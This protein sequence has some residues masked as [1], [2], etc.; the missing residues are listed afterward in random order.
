M[1]RLLLAAALAAAA[2]MPAF[3]PALAQTA[4]P[5]LRCAVDVDDRRVFQGRAWQVMV[6]CSG[7][8]GAGSVV[9]EAQPDD[10][11][12]DLVVI[13]AG[14]RLRL[15]QYAHGL[16]EGRITDQPGVISTRGTRVSLSLP[17]EALLNVD[18]EVI[19]ARSPIT[20]AP[21]HFQVVVP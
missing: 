11:L 21:G 18:G 3:A 9:D 12:L 8:F 10:G 4:Q 6:A 17:D 1:R 7:A 16:R 20:I 5:P 2:S 13:Q 14:R 19:P 15:V